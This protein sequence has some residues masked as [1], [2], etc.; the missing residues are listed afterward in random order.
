MDMDPDDLPKE[1]MEVINNAKGEKDDAKLAQTDEK[2]VSSL[3]HVPVQ[4]PWSPRSPSVPAR[5]P[6]EKSGLIYPPRISPVFPHTIGRL[7]PAFSSKV[8]KTKNLD[9]NWSK[10]A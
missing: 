1:S 10:L 7:I 5:V 3:T 4:K 6:T 8:V 9:Y 2:D